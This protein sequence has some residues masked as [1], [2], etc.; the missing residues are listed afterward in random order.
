MFGTPFYNEGL[1]KVIIAFGQ[2]FN[3]IVIESANKDTGAI[4]KRIKVPLAYAPKEKFLIR[5][6]EQSNLDN[7]A[8][9]ITL[10]RL[11]FEISELQYDP[12]RKLTRVQKFRTE[13]TPLTRSQSVANMD[14]MSLESS[15]GSGYIEFEQPNTATGNAEYPLLETSP[16][17]FDDSKKQSFNYTP[18]PYNISLN[19]YSFTATAENGLQIIEQILPFFQPDYTI[20]V[21]VMPDINMK[22]D[23][24]VVLDS[25]T[26]EDT[27]SGDFTTRRAVIY[28][29][30]FTAKTYLFGPTTNQGIIKKVQS[31]LY[32]DTNTTT[33]KREGRITVVPD[34]LS[35]DP[36][37]DFGFTTTIQ[38]FNDG[39]KYN[40]I[41]GVDE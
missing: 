21:N 29:L 32:A 1:R 28:T 19:L 20:T 37:D 36:N 39:K 33:A 24:P 31:E 23:V 25:V 11:G 12:S 2:L 35:A 6:D 14:R 38:N 17:D 27:Y 4:L 13:T 18:V 30:K 10:P 5:L 41:T 26:Y 8:M 15:L 22:R 16:T 40:V 9:A 3:N 7:R 34:P